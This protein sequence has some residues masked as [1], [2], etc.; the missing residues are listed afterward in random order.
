MIGIEG[1]A[2][3]CVFLPRMKIRLKLREAGPR[4]KQ[5]RTGLLEFESRNQKRKKT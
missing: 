3:D 5:H 1:R 4:T 2:P